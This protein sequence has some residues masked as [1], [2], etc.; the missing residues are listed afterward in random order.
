MCKDGVETIGVGGSGLLTSELSL[1]R[2]MGDGE[3]S[4]TEKLSNET[5]CGCL[6]VT[7]LPCRCFGAGGGF[8]LLFL[9]SETS[10]V[11]SSSSDSAISYD[12]RGDSGCAACGGSD[13][14]CRDI[15]EVSVLLLLSN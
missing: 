12:V 10:P 9:P 7:S 15:D 5:V 8:L 11:C 6:C 13:I 1:D 2:V 3:G 4:D 14:D